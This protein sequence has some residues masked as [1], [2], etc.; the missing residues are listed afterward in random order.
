MVQMI[1]HHPIL[2]VPELSKWIASLGSGLAGADPSLVGAEQ[3]LI[4]FHKRCHRLH[5]DTISS[6][7]SPQNLSSI[8]GAQLEMM[9]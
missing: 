5:K 3:V 7:L 6:N 8:A 2:Q 1:H 4:C 9:R